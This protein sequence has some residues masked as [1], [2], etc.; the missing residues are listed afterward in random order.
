MDR[1]AHGLA[2]F[3]TSSNSIALLCQPV[4]RDALTEALNWEMERQLRRLLAA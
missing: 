1:K 2:I 3:G 4:S